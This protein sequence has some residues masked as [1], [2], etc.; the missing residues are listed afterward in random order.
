MPE[1]PSHT[2]TPHPERTTA[3]RYE[4]EAQK[5]EA[6]KINKGKVIDLAWCLSFFGKRGREA[7]GE[8]FKIHEEDHEIIYK[9]IIYFLAHERET[10]RLGLDLNKGILLTGP[11]GC[12]KTTLMN[13]MK[14]IPP[15]ERSYTVKPCRDI[16]FE[17]IKE[18]YEVIDRY[19]K[20]AFTGQ[21][22]KAY[23]FD[24]LGAEQSL[25]YYGNECN[26]MSEILLSRYDLFISSQM[27]THLTTNLSASELENYYGLRLRSRLKSMVNLIPFT[28]SQIDKRL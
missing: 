15:I 21:H 8:K 13:L 11:V 24:D 18:G 10:K 19:S 4:T 1:T 5:E 16:S 26:I 9:L 12:G 14:L 6:E 20:L 2:W 23:C 17:F 28:S 7:Y 3:N 27:Q 22:P 25:K